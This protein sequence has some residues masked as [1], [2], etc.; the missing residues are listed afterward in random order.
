MN[1]GGTTILPWGTPR[2]SCRKIL[3]YLATAAGK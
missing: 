3:E 1:R 2:S